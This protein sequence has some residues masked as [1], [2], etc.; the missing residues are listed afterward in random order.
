MGFNFK[1]GQLSAEY[2]SVKE[3][4]EK[5]GTPLYIYS[6]KYMQD[7]FKKLDGAFSRK[8]IIS[9][10]IKSNSNLNI[11]KLFSTLGSGADIVSKCELFRAKKAGV[12]PHKVVFSGVA[13]T[14]DEIEY[15]LENDILMINAESY[16]EVAI[17]NETAARLGKKARIAL[18]VNPDVDPKTHP[19]ISTGLKKNK[20][21]IPYDEAFDVYLKAKEMNNI[22]VYGIQFHIGSQLTDISPIAEASMKVADLMKHLRDKNINF[23][24][25]DVGGGL[26]IVYSDEDNPPDVKEYAEN[27]ERAFSDFSNAVIV[28]EPG[29]FLTGNGGILITKV[30]YH[31]TNGEK[32]FLI[33]D[34]GMNDLLRPSLYHAYHKIRPVVQSDKPMIKCDIVGPICETGDFF[35]RDYEIENIDNQGLLSVFSAGAYGFSMASNYNSKPKAA[36]ILVDGSSYSIIRKRETCEDLIRG[37]L[38]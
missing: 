7:Q 24:A 8:H 34:A 9:F 20:F 18:R 13:K 17:I 11:I 23:R 3:I 4:A 22:E 31:K 33:I 38:I 2:L 1:S 37:E 29:R 21:G 28:C 27:V 16:D 14:V 12:D 26:G 36:E 19:Y 6:K 32:N 30:I 10:A 5:E 25:V 15:A 35:A